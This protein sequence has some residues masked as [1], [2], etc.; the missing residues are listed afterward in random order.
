MRPIISMKH[1]RVEFADCGDFV[2]MG[3]LPPSEPNT[4]QTNHSANRP[5]NDPEG[6]ETDRIATH[7]VSIDNNRPKRNDTI[8]AGSGKGGAQLRFT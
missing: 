6:L 8:G 7:T 5:G 1:D 4:L 2:H 3:T